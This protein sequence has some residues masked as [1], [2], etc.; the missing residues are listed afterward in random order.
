MVLYI[1][2]LIWEA[3]DGVNLGTVLFP[4]IIGHNKK[5]AS[6]QVRSLPRIS[7]TGNTLA[8]VLHFS[9]FTAA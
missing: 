9:N 2:E 3:C 8:E 1:E 4:L 7:V 6:L 5:E